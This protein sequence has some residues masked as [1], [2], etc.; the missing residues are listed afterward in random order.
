MEFRFKNQERVKRV[1]TRIVNKVA[2]IM[3]EDIGI[4][5]VC[6]PIP[7]PVASNTAILVSCNCDSELLPYILA[8]AEERVIERIEIMRS[9]N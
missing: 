2:R 4:V 7:A 3:G 1:L 6:M 8:H 5:I 9:M